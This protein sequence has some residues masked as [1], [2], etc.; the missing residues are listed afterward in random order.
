VI[1]Y[2]STILTLLCAISIAQE[3]YFRHLYATVQPTLEQRCESWDN[4]CAIFNIMLSS[5]INMQACGP[6]LCPAACTTSSIPVKSGSPS[7]T[8]FHENSSTA[9]SSSFEHSASKSRESGTQTRYLQSTEEGIVDKEGVRVCWCN[10]PHLRDIF[11][12]QP[13][14]GPQHTVCKVMNEKR[15]DYNGCVGGCSCPMDGCGTWWMSLCT[16][17]RAGSS[18]GASSTPRALRSWRLCAIATESGPSS[19]SSTTSR[20]SS[21]SLAS[22]P[23]SLRQVKLCDVLLCDRELCELCGELALSELESITTLCDVQQVLNSSDLSACLTV[24]CC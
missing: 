8:Q 23:S 9:L 6:P 4:Y 18:T 19:P 15:L 21:T 2:Y 16:S 12:P 22:S 20:P 14:R 7:G 5:S 11:L 10:P 17:S 13:R 1:L 3:M 24:C